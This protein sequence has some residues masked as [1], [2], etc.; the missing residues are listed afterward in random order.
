MIEY[1]TN[2]DFSILY[3]IQD[4]LRS[5]F[6]DNSMFLCSESNTGGFIWILF[7]VVLLFFKKTRYC[8]IAVLLTMGLDT[9]LAEGVLKYVVCR[10][11]PCNLV[12]DVTMLI[13]KPRSYSF[14]SNH[15]AS[16]FAAA[17]AVFITMRKKRFAIPVFTFAVLVGFS[18]LYLF[19][20]FPSDVLAGALFGTLMAFLVCFILKKSGLHA[21]LQR[22]NIIS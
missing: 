1:I 18:R 22:K 3:W 21:L 16:S 14:P 8:G 10:V 17:A 4:N 19:V 20:H 2:I 9:L 15:T 5:T 6:M 13:N 12:N 7:S 11:R